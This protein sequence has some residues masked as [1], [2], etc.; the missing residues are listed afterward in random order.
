MEGIYQL[1]L[2]EAFGFELEYIIVD[3][4]TLQ[5]KPLAAELIEQIP[6]N[7]GNK[8]EFPVIS[9]S[10]EIA[11]HIIELKTSIP[12]ADLF[13]LAEGFHKYIKYL[14]NILKKYDAQLLPTAIHP[15]MNPKRETNL[16][17]RDN[18]E[19]Y[20]AYDKVF[21]CHCHGWSNIQSTHINLPYSK[22]E[23]FGRLHAAVRLILPLLPAIAAS[24]PIVESK[25]NGILDNRLKYYK[26]SKEKIGFLTG[27]MIPE[28]VFS[29]D[30]YQSSIIENIHLQISPFDLHNIFDPYRLN[31][32]G[33]T[34]RFDRNSVE[35][36]ILDIQECPSA[37]MAIASL[38]IE[39]IKLLV[40]E[41]FVSYE[42]QQKWTCEALQDILNLTI[43]NGEKAVIDH[44]DY[45]QLF[46]INSIY[47]VSAKDIWFYL[48]DY[49]LTHCITNL[50]MWKSQ[51]VVILNEGTLA[52][53]I[54]EALNND[55]SE[56]QIK[57]LYKKLSKCL[58]KNVMFLA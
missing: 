2:F 57:N 42:S 8:A 37:D 9:I 43:E 45:L 28:P 54:L 18:H 17:K 29:T 16:W 21:N 44:P 23:E 7:N 6:G 22:E 15:L 55:Y 58:K 47:P 30:Q 20:E 19:L 32:R 4:E 31:S 27:A 41:T 26:K 38:V 25:V 35:I 39:S 46:G 3:K 56:A 11:S 24:S 34:A 49:L 48:L 51:L 14:N 33:A 36:R 13:H 10:N 5:I 52:S 1:S 40:D 50:E 53:R 12:N